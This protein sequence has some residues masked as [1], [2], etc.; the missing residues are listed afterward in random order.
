MSESF[1][2]KKVNIISSLEIA[3]MLLLPA[4]IWLYVQPSFIC[5]LR[6]LLSWYLFSRPM[7]YEFLNLHCLLLSWHTN[8]FPYLLAD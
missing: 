2:N 6:Y 8:M 7:S 1:S 5:R 3:F 4:M